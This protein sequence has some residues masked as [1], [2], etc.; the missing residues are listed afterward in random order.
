MTTLTSRLRK[1]GS[2]ER[3]APTRSSIFRLRSRS[4]CAPSP[5]TSPLLDSVLRGSSI[6]RATY[7]SLSLDEQ[8]RRVHA[9][10]AL[11]RKMLSGTAEKLTGRAFCAHVAA[12]VGAEHV[13]LCLLRHKQLKPSPVCSSSGAPPHCALVAQLDEM[14]HAADEDVPLR[15][16]MRGR[17]RLVHPVCARGEV[18]GMVEAVAAEGAVF[19]H[20]DAALLPPAAWLAAPLLLEFS[21]EPFRPRQ[22]M[23]ESGGDDTAAP[24]AVAT[25]DEVAHTAL[26]VS[27]H[28]GVHDGMIQQIRNAAKKAVGADMC[29]VFLVSADRR[30]LL[31]RMSE[32]EGGKPFTCPVSNGLAGYVALTGERLCLPDAHMDERFNSEMDHKT[33]YRTRQ[34]LCI[35]IISAGRVVGVCQCVNKRGGGEF[36]RED[37]ELL[38]ALSVVF[39]VCIENAHALQSESRLRQQQQALLTL[40]QII[41]TKLELKPLVD[42]VRSVACS[43]MEAERCT[44]FLKQP[45]SD[46]LI[47]QLS[48]AE[49]GSMCSIPVGKGIAGHCAQSNQTLNIPS[50]YDDPRFEASTDLMTQKITRNLLAVPIPMVDRTTGRL[51]EDK[52]LG[53]LQ[54]SNKTNG[55]PFSSADEALLRGICALLSV[56]IGNATLYHGACEAKRLSQAVLSCSTEWIFAIGVDGHLV[57][58]NRPLHE[59]FPL[60]SEAT[61]FS[62]PCEEW[63]AS[64]TANFDAGLLAADV[65]V[66]ERGGIVERSEQLLGSA[67]RPFRVRWK[68]MP[69]K[70]HT[71]AA[72]ASAPASAPSSSDGAADVAQTLLRAFPTSTL[73]VLVVVMDC[74]QELSL[75][76]EV[77]HHKSD[78]AALREVV[79]SLLQLHPTAKGAPPSLVHEAMVRHVDAISDG[80]SQSEVHLQAL[81]QLLDAPS[82]AEASAQLENARSQLQAQG[83]LPAPPAALRLLHRSGSLNWSLDLR[84]LPD[85]D[86]ESVL[87][88]LRLF[89]SAGLVTAFRLSTD[90]LLAAI[91]ELRRHYYPNHFHNWGHALMVMHKTFLI[92]CSTAVK[93]SLSRLDLLALF[94]AALGHDVG[95]LGRN[96]AFEIA[97]Q[98][99]VA[100]TYNDQSPLENH[101]CATL[102]KILHQSNLF[103]PLNRS[104]RTYT[105]KLIIQL[106]I[107]TDLA[108]HD[109]LKGRLR[110]L[111]NEGGALAAPL[112]LPNRTTI[113][114]GVLH[115][116]DF[117]SPTLPWEASVGWVNALGC[118]FAEQVELERKSG[119]AESTFLLSP[120][121]QARAKNEV[122][123]ISRFVLPLW[124]LMGSA[125]P[126]LTPCCAMVRDNLSRW[127]TLTA[128]GA[129][130]QAVSR[131]P[132]PSPLLSIG[133]EEG[134]RAV[135]QREL[136]ALPQVPSDVR[137]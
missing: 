98:S 82:P 55:A 18:I 63:L 23:D 114:Q 37:E 128:E 104:Q 33:G 26:T 3:S 129:D 51:M 120:N 112:S 92:A 109:D 125:F 9:L 105:R 84:T 71:V 131:L 64:S 94:I 93:K 108:H 121:L 103:A 54:V 24:D 49:G 32:A 45:L 96:N 101:H 90:A 20:D 116:A 38:N 89:Q 91:L 17:W 85:A 123:F 137:G 13:T 46:S 42:S 126:E 57:Q 97:I 60:A 115:A 127:Q 35:P 136:E 52:V 59:L 19:S 61:M 134:R 12:L 132:T 40:S 99:P 58:T 53:V 36:T 75:A 88:P 16:Q 28:E 70:E 25:P 122:G 113:L 11:Q 81:R 7:T 27:P 21:Q 78:A 106:I 87:L 74:T 22:P 14:V 76:S 65:R 68:V 83:G 43:A 80:D 119:L 50:A 69:L 2:I 15:V 5:T 48:E 133:L 30:Q 124:E 6:P 47:F 77:A 111:L 10:F 86:E 95:H 117:Y 4:T 62:R 34:V 8:T 79:G 1:S 102:C 118:E 67:T 73:G 135:L 44:L 56:A 107:A 41:S 31:G 39:A 110:N 29:T 130:L 66:A 72:P 100:L